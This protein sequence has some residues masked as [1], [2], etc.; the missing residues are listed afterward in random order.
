MKQLSRRTLVKGSLLAASAPLFY[1]SRQL[2][3]QPAK[4][5]YSATSPE[6][7]AMLD[8]YRAGVKAM[9]A[10]PSGDPLHWNR[11][12]EIHNRTC[13]HGNWFFLP[14]HRAYLFYL[15]DIIRAMTAREDF[16]LP[17]WDWTNDR[18]IPAKLIA[19]ELDPDILGYGARNFTP[20][21]ETDV[22]QDVID[23]ILANTDFEAFASY[24]S[25][26]QRGGQ[27]GASAALEATPHN[28]VHGRVGGP[29]AYVSSSALDP[30]FWLHHCNIDR[31]W[32]Q[33]QAAGNQNTD[34]QDWLA[35]ELNHQWPDFPFVNRDGVPEH[36]TVERAQ[37]TANWGYQYDLPSLPAPPNPP[38]LRLDTSL[39]G[40]FMSQAMAAPA[41]R[42]L[43]SVYKNEQSKT[44][45]IKQPSSHRLK[46]D[47]TPLLNK[48]GIDP[49]RKGHFKGENRAYTVLS[50][51][52]PPSN[53]SGFL[54]RVFLNCDYL[55]ESTPTDDPHYV[56]S[57]AFFGSKHMRHNPDGIAFVM[58]ITDTL[59]NLA[60]DASETSGNLDVQLLSIPFADRSDDGRDFSVGNIEIMSLKPLLPVVG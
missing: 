43:V 10:L 7:E 50:N 28:I 13:P 27:G 5:R 30:I 6:G 1:S 58:D 46:I 36:P 54:V 11:I 37:F 31:I 47:K 51:I 15:E 8:I 52:R 48:L 44:T 59:K 4:T 23:R 26:E 29:M 34:A 45:R 33:W 2:L 60:G 49:T 16:T 21:Q 22:G 39:R 18:D 14:W 9:N 25:S 32:A 41:P 56:T 17:Y 24:R 57:F 20:L 40:F 35:Y 53:D 38:V 19:N 55:N 42:S 3:S 12:A